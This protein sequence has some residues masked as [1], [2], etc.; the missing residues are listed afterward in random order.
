[1]A[2][3]I[4]NTAPPTVAAGCA[5]ATQPTSTL[6]RATLTGPAGSFAS[7]FASVNFYY[8]DN[9]TGKAE[10]IGPASV[11]VTDNTI[12]S[13]RTYTYTGSWDATSLKVRPAAIGGVPTQFIAI[14]VTATGDALISSLGPVVNIHGN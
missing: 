12:T 6:L 2:A 11:V 3:D 1:V 13:T 9:I 7:P 10:L 8:L 14:G 5:S 4:C